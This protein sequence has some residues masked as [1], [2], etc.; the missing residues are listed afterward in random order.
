ML[1]GGFAPAALLC[2]HK[3]GV[4]TPWGADVELSVKTDREWIV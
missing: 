1:R 3:F 2:V 4:G